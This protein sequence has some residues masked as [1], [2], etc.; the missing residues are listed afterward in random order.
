[1]GLK[2]NYSRLKQELLNNKNICPENRKLFREF[3]EFEEYKLKRINN[4]SNIDDNS[5]R[6]LYV[7]IMRF[8]NV[9]Q[10]F[11]NK[12]LKKLIEAD[13][14]RVY[15]GLEDGTI[16]TKNGKPF[17]D[18]KSYYTKV[19]KSKLFEMAGKKEIAKKV[20]EFYKPK[21]DNEVRF[22]EFDDFKK[23][24]QVAIQ[25]E[26]KF[27]LWLAF[28][29]GE[30]IASLLR[31]TKKDFVRQINQD[32]KEPEYI[33]N[34]RREI[35]KRARKP[36]SEITNFRE[37]REFADI[38]LKDLK[39]DETIFKFG[40]RQA[41]KFFDRAAEKSGIKCKPQGQSPTWKDLRSSMACYL[42]KEG[43]TTDEINARLGHKPSSRELD[44][45]VNLF[46]IGRHKPKKKL[47]ETD[48][49]K[50]KAEI[51]EIRN[52]EKLK[53]M[54]IEELKKKIDYILK[55]DDERT[56]MMMIFSQEFKKQKG[57]KDYGKF[58][59]KVIEIYKREHN[60]AP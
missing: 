23:L 22:I 29:I 45:Y 54:R 59:E 18:R 32:S 5:Y 26:Q 9:N 58:F 20:M 10:W 50:M 24:I 39:D 55:I 25:P 8:K 35:L 46:A 40:Y 31:L 38:V 11:K 19:F 41:V 57:E 28:D 47:Y 6:T 42:L 12:P 48:Y 36:R 1:M 16:K 33:V 49:N 3:F 43:W 14:K 4:L 53:D 17:I 21:V 27:L 51:E 2:E 44:K 7:Y 56:K 13:I 15:D 52:R 34:L 37:T 30:N 60:L